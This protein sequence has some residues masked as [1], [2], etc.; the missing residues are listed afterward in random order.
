MIVTLKID[1]NTLE[2]HN[3]DQLVSVNDIHQEGDL[4]IV[5]ISKPD[6]EAST[7]QQ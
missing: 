6:P 7:W 1:L 5:E 3:D 4:L 2:V